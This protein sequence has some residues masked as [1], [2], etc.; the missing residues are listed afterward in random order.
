MPSPTTRNQIGYSFAPTF[1]NAELA[2]RSGGPQAQGPL[3]VLSYR[4]KRSPAI[5]GGFSPL[6]GDQMSGAS[7]SALIQS[8]LHTVLGP[9]AAQAFLSSL[10]SGVGGGMGGGMSMPANNAPVVKPGGEGVK[11]PTEGGSIAPPAGPPNFID[12]GYEQPRI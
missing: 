9:D 7:N 5:T 11:L 6:A 8:I 10:S 2:G 12:Y 3:Q 4:L 1:E